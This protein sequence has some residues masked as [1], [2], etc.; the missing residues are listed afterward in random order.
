MNESE[1]L[2]CVRSA[3]CAAK[4]ELIQLQLDDQYCRALDQVDQRLGEQGDVVAGIYCQLTKALSDFVLANDDR[5]EAVYDVM[6]MLLF[7]TG[8]AFRVLYPSYNFVGDNS[9]YFS[10][11]VF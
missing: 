1:A 8:T 2:R 9:L 3:L 7:R 11:I 4:Q 6:L 5:S 10:T